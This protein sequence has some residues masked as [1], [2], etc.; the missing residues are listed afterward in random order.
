MSG[1]GNWKNT[2][3]STTPGK[4]NWKN[5]AFSI[6]SGKGNWK[7]GAFSISLGKGNW[8]NIAF[9]IAH[10]KGN[11]KSTAFGRTFATPPAEVGFII[12]VMATSCDDIFFEKRQV[13]CQCKEMEEI[14]LLRIHGGSHHPLLWRCDWLCFFNHGVTSL[15]KKQQ[16]VTGCVLSMHSVEE[17]NTSRT[18][19]GPY[20][21][22][23]WLCHW[24]CF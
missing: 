17:M 2:A 16:L 6:T 21:S 14:K 13:S 20:H 24:A 18:H 12:H 10:K 11:W 15:L 7:N 22:P 5:T 9:S 23:L 8:K 4:G 1:K 19:D 3:F